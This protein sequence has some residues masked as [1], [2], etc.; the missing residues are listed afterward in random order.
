VTQ[1]VV[2]QDGVAVRIASQTLTRKAPDYTTE[3]RR[4]LDAALAV[5]ARQGSTARARVADIVA[6]AGLSNDAFYRHFPSKDALVAALLEDGAERLTS[7]VS[8]QMAKESTPEGQVR[9]WVEGVLAQ[10]KSETAATTMAVL[11]TGSGAVAGITPAGQDATVT[12]APLLY[13]PLAR[14]G[15]KRPELDA[16]LAGHAVLGRLADHLWAHTQPTRAEID[17]ITRVCIGRCEEPV[18]EAVRAARKTSR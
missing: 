5:I 9:R 17:H 6:E 15:S 1:N 14:L 18:R 4:L 16:S 13:E 8:H 11:W 12:L 2:L 10:A 3:V 7:Y